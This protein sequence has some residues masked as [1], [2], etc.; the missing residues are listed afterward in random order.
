MQVQII[1]VGTAA[2]SWAGNSNNANRAVGCG[3]SLFE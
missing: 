1:Q 2:T 3:T